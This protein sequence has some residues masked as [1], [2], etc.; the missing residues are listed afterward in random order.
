MAL[1]NEKYAHPSPKWNVLIPSA[2]G[3][4]TAD[5]FTGL[6]DGNRCSLD[7]SS[8]VIYWAWTKNYS[9]YFFKKKQKLPNTGGLCFSNSNFS[10]YLH[11]NMK[12]T[13]YAWMKCCWSNILCASRNVLHSAMLH[14]IREV[15][16]Y[17]LHSAIAF[18]VTSH[19]VMEIIA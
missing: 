18:N 16:S 14:H 12:Q 7:Y 3:W 8:K 11:C 4:Q 13:C 10:I 1:S 5:N 15:E 19:K 9:G 2:A 17:Q 6:D